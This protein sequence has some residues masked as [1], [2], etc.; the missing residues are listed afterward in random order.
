[1]CEKCGI[2]RLAGRW[3]GRFTYVRYTADLS[4]KGLDDLGLGHARPEEVQKLDSV[5]AIPQMQEVGRAVA[6]R[7]VHAEHFARFPA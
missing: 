3:S 6:A 4:R 7:K 1:V 2:T 5:D